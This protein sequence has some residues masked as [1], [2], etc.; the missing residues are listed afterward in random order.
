MIISVKIKI[1]STIEN[2]D[3]SGLID[4]DP[5]VSVS[6]A[7]GT[8]RYSDGEAFINFNEQ[9]DG[10]KV[11]TE[12]KCLGGTVTVRRDGAIESYMHFSKDESHH[13]VYT[14]SP[15]RFDATV[16]SKRVKIKLDSEGGE[17]DLL[18]NMTIGGA[19]KNARMKIW[20]SKAS[21]QV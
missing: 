1:E 16:T 6:E 11:H 13:S 9:T 19:D 2:L 7:M 15:Y 18:Y 14:I 3:G 8:Y 20:I 10:G 17:I 12:I 21:R 5:E 4:G